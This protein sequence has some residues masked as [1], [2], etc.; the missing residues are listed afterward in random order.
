LVTVVKI[1]FNEN[2]VSFIR[3]TGSTCEMSIITW[4]EYGQQVIMKQYAQSLFDWGRVYGCESSLS[5][6]K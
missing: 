4:A 6:W 3:C 2:V 1:Y 5:R